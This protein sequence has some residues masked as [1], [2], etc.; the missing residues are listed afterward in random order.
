MGPSSYAVNLHE[1][2]YPTVP[3]IIAHWTLD[4]RADTIYLCN[5]VGQHPFRSF[6]PITLMYNQELQ[7]LFVYRSP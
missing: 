1:L 4:L 6:F 2:R 3:A 5:D 7:N